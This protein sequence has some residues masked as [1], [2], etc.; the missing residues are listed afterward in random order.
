MTSLDKAIL[1][2]A[3]TLRSI[4]RDRLAKRISVEREATNRMLAHMEVTQT[5]LDMQAAAELRGKREA[6][7]HVKKDASNLGL[8]YLES[9]IDE[10]LAALKGK[11]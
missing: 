8:D 1:K 7:N 11:S 2:F 5:I 3:K 9:L 4:D 10:Q 6:F